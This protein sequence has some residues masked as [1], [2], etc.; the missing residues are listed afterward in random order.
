MYLKESEQI[1]VLP[2]HVKRRCTIYK[3][4][5]DLAEAFMENHAVFQKSFVSA[6][7]TQKLNGKQKHA[8]SCNVRDA[9]ENSSESDPVEVRVNRN[10]L[11]L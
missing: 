4:D 6:Y 1:N 3:N 2:L 10:N 9:S 7:N 8:E 11:D 5:Q